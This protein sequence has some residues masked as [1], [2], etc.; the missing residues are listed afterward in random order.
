MRRTRVGTIAL[1]A[2]LGLGACG[3]GATA[4]GATLSGPE[5]EAIAT[6]LMTSSLDASDQGFAAAPA[7]TDPLTARAVVDIDETVTAVIPCPLGG[8]VAV[9]QAVVGSVDTETGAMDL[10]AAQ[11][12]TH[13]DCAA[14]DQEGSFDFVLNGA[15]DVNTSLTLSVDGLGALDMGGS[16]TGA[17]DWSSGDRSGTCSLTMEFSGGMDANGAA[18]FTLAGSICGVDVTQSVSVTP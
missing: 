15:P 8:S 5:A 10:D 1:L 11:V 9:S 14:R 4:P 7:A 16:M 13:Q 17:I 6:F 2:T 3:D 18:S 12:Q